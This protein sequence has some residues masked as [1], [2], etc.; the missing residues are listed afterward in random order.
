MI[1]WL[2]CTCLD[3]GNR[4]ERVKR[5]HQRCR[6]TPSSKNSAT[7]TPCPA[8]RSSLTARAERRPPG[9]TRGKEAIKPASAAFGVDRLSHPTSYRRSNP[10][11]NNDAPGRVPVQPAADLMLLTVPQ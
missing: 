3:V 4:R 6:D 5:D 2:G 7:I 10:S 8:I 11:P 1:E 9:R